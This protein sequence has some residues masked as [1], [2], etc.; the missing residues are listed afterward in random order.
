MSEAPVR[1]AETHAR[2]QGHEK[3]RPS[4]GA[5]EGGIE[6]GVEPVDGPHLR[7]AAGRRRGIRMRAEAKRGS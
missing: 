5:E 1:V 7:V 3:Q 6:D 2:V 4:D